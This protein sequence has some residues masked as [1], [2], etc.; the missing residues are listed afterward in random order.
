MLLNEYTVYFWNAFNAAAIMT[1]PEMFFGMCILEK[2]MLR[3]MVN[4]Y[5]QDRL[6]NILANPFKNSLQR[7]NCSAGTL[8]SQ[9]SRDK[10][11]GANAK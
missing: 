5:D 6:Y 11:T 4:V 3:K 8:H 2:S 10:Y 9:N 7:K 1:R